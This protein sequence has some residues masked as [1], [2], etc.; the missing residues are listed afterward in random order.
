MLGK[1]PG[2]PYSASGHREEGDYLI[3]ASHSAQIKTK[4]DP[5]NKTSVKVNTNFHAFVLFLQLALQVKWGKM[6]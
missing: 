2:F 5:T 3:A 1:P 4:V 6:N